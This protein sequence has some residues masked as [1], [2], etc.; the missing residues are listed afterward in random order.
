MNI[1]RYCEKHEMSGGEQQ[2][3]KPECSSGGGSLNGE[4]K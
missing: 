4:V 3:I 1:F 2:I